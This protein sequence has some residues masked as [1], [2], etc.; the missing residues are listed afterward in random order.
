PVLVEVEPAILRQRLLARGREQGKD[1]EERLQRA[2]AP[3]PAAGLER[4]VRIDNSGKLEA[5][6][7]SLENIVRAVLPVR[8]MPGTPQ[9]AQGSAA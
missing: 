5:A 1:L 2:L 6:V 8:S 9:G 7:D 3:L 4:L